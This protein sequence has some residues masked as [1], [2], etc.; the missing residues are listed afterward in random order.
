MSEGRIPDMAVTDP[1]AVEQEIIDARNAYA[2]ANPGIP[3]Y[4]TDQA[5]DEGTE[6]DLTEIEGRLDDLEAPAVSALTPTTGTADIDLSGTGNTY[7]T[8]TLTGNPTYTSSNRAAGRSVV[9]KVIAGGSTRTLAFPAWVFVGE[10]PTE[11][12]SGKIGIL[13]VT[14]FD[15]TDANAVAAWAVQA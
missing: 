7:L 3:L 13:S 15:D 10:E 14:W 11:I 2:N 6:T 5:D 8:H 4:L 1:T 9:V 12:A